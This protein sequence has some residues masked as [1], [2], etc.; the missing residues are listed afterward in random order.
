MDVE[1]MLSESLEVRR[2]VWYDCRLTVYMQAV[3]PKLEL[4]KNIEEAA[5]AV[6]EML[7]STIQAGDCEFSCSAFDDALTC[8]SG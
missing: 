4:V 8:F 2:V 7:N 1:F 5:V 3:R 6:D